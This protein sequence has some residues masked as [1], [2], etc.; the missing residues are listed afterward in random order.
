VLV[1]ADPIRRIDRLTRYSVFARVETLQAANATGWAEDHSN[2]DETIRSFLPPLLPVSVLADISQVDLPPEGL[3]M[4]VQASG[5]DDPIDEDDEMAAGERTRR[6]TT[7]LVRDARF[8]RQVVSAYKGLCAM[9]EIDLDLVQ[10][11][12]IYPASAPLSPDK[13]WNGLSLCANHHVAFDRHMIWVDPDN[14]AI[15][16]HPK[17]HEQSESK[18]AV[19]A[20]IGTTISHLMEPV[21]SKFRPRTEMF[22]KRYDHFADRYSWAD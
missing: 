1:S 9:C 4:A 14:R 2:T 22:E 6:A 21:N 16:L 10:G 5:L 3:R 7:A 19:E 15:V 11:A 20:L 18:P 12:H 17:I 8:G 13:T